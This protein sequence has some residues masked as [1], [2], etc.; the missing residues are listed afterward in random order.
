MEQAKWKEV[1]RKHASFT[2][3][4]GAGRAITVLPCASLQQTMQAWTGWALPLKGLFLPRL[5]V[6][7]GRE[8]K[9]WNKNMGASGTCKGLGV[10]GAAAL[11]CP[12]LTRSTLLVKPT[13]GTRAHA[14]R[15]LSWNDL[16][17]HFFHCF[18]LWYLLANAAGPGE[19]L[20]TCSWC[21]VWVME[22]WG[23]SSASD[24]GE[25]IAVFWEDSWGI[26][27]LQ[28]VSFLPLSLLQWHLLIFPSLILSSAPDLC[29]LPWFLFVVSDTQ[30]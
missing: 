27:W 23:R 21:S 14:R 29:W 30:A 7:R 8:A 2:P 6:F 26:R 5:G 15:E 19:G 22:Q 16:G 18:E 10:W 25:T 11:Q 3:W 20:W 4:N 17:I 9:A 13:G 24:N 1:G 28:P 12:C